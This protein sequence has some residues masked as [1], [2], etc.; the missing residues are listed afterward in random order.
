M[1]TLIKASGYRYVDAALAMSPNSSYPWYDGYND[2]G[3]HPTV[4]GAKVLASRVMLD[5]PEISV[6][7]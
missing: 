2:D 6:L 1:G 4:L 7:E 5:F 3:V